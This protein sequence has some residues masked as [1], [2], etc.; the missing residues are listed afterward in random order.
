MTQLFV[1]N[2]N[3]N[4]TGVSATAANV[5]RR[6]VDQFDLSLVGEALPGCPDPITTAEARSLS[7]GPDPFA[8]WHVRRNTEMRAGIW[9]RDV[10]RLPIKLVFT[11]AAQRRH[12]AFPRALISRMDAVI[13]TTDEAATYVP[14]V[15]AVVP[16]GVDT[17][18]FRPASDRALA[19][20]RTGYPGKRGLAAVGRIRPEKGTD[21]FVK[22][23]IEL[24]PR[25][26]DVTALVIGKAGRKDQDFLETLRR[27]VSSAG[28]SKRILFPGELPPEELPALLRGLTAL[29]PLPRYEGYG[30]TPLEAMSSAVPF[31]SSDTGYFRS[32]SNQGQAG[33]VLAEDVVDQAVIALDGLLAAPDRLEAMGQL[34]R[35]ASV[36]NFDVQR[37]AQGIANVYQEL[38]SN[39]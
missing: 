10:L 33:L 17:A 21:R 23:M 29:V 24:L 26:K 34:A 18:L 25:H 20:K 7:R 4:Y 22:T 32:F 28:L 13:A 31:I 1:T 27:D 19:W 30:M 6:Q 38:W 14:H 12:S 37:E 35:K 36:D 16:H 15:R 3:R 39:G 2:F 11:S 8:I 5:V 9:A